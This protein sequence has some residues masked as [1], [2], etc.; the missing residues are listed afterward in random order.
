[1]YI[2]EFD[3]ADR[4]KITKL[5]KVLIIMIIKSDNHFVSSAPWT[6]LLPTNLVILAWKVLVLAETLSKKNFMKSLLGH[7]FVVLLARKLVC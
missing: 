5:L 6:L 2:K 7:P 3:L 1:M 4:V